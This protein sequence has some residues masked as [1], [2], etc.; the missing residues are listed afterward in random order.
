MKK[1]SRSGTD[2]KRIVCTFFALLLLALPVPVL[3]QSAVLQGGPT[4]PGHLSQYV[5][6][7]SSQAII[8]DSGTAAGGALGTNPS[9]L[10]LTVRNPVGVYPA[11]NVGNG[12]FFTNLCDRDGPVGNDHYLCFGT[13]SNGGGLI[14]YGAEGTASPLP[15][16]FNVNG[17]NYTFPFLASGVIGPNTSVVNDFACWNNTTGTLLKDCP[18]PAA[19]VPLPT[20]VS[21]GG[22]FS[23]SAAAGKFATGINTSGMVVYTDLLGVSNTWAGVQTNSVPPIFTGLSGYLKGNNALALTA[24]ATV[25]LTDM[26]LQA[27]NTD[28]MNATNG[29]AAPT[30]VAIP[31]CTASTCAINYTP[32]TGWGTNT[33]IAAASATTATSATSVTGTNVVTNANLAQMQPNTVKCNN[34]GLTANALDCT[35]AQINTLTNAVTTTTLN[36][37]TLP[38]AFTNATIA[39]TRS[40]VSSALSALTIT[41]ASG[42]NQGLNIGLNGTGTLTGGYIQ[43]FN[44]I[45]ISSDNI[46]AGAGFVVGVNIDD[47]F[48]G[49]STQGGREAFQA[50]AYLQAATSGS[51]A[52][53]N[54]VGIAGVAD[55]QSTDGGSNPASSGTSLGAVFGGNFVAAAE[56]G[57]TALLNVSGAEFNTTMKTGSSAWAKS[58][59]QFSGRSDDVVNGTV[60]DAML[61]LYNQATGGP[62]WNDGILFD[63]TN[64]FWPINSA[65]TILRTAGS[66]TATN[67][68]DLSATT[69]SGSSFKSTGFSVGPTGVVNGLKALLS[70]ATGT[71]GAQGINATIVQTTPNAGDTSDSVANLSYTLTASSATNELIVRALQFGAT[72]NLTGGGSISNLRGIDVAMNDNASTTTTNQND[73]YIEQG[74]ATGTVGTHVGVYISSGLIG[75]TKY[76]IFDQGLYNEQLGPT[77]VSSLTAIAGTTS[78]APIKL[79]SGTNLTTA[80]AGAFEYD[81]FVAYFSPAASTRS[82]VAAEQIMYLGTAYTLTNATGVQKLFNGSTNGQVTLPVGD[83]QF[84]CYV[85]ISALPVTGT[86]GYAMA[87]TATYTQS[88]VADAQRVAAGTAGASFTSFNTAANTAVT[89]T[90][91]TTTGYM[92]IRGTINVTVTGTVIP[93]FS[94]TTTAAAAVIGVGSFFKI[95]PFSGAN[96]ATNI[97]IGNWN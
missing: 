89:P 66:G 59:A 17:T 53:R 76:G 30:A 83:Y 50:T 56:T 21:L 63:G 13:N 90:A 81:G 87:G 42:V 14:A 91:A 70:N 77:T 22:V 68:I 61:W 4:T 39:D 85:N 72:N 34:T 26:A 54:Y 6:Q 37:S 84:E 95:S 49:A 45:A 94:M 55:A 8:Q 33:S 36:N 10:G 74:T 3:A 82:T 9:E 58:I 28:T 93:Q 20:A 32:G 88:W 15:L 65:G 52:N 38:A 71:S 1:M 7:S 19:V 31:T 2:L 60:V 96:G 40:S 46:N 41:G 23:S 5:G 11:A 51:N 64:N 24:S 44:Q 92:H 47:L 86:F 69:F 62:K 80:A 75:T 25:P 78:V 35:A 29:S 18:S 67:G 16:N 43:H 57:S 48:G 73:I 79:T 27:G 97:A 12:P